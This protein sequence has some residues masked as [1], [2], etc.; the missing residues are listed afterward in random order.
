[1]SHPKPWYKSWARWAHDPD[2]LE[3]SLSETGAW[4]HLYA[5]GHECNDGGRLTG[6]NGNPL[7]RLAQLDAMHLRGIQEARAY[8]NMVAKRLK[9]GALRWDGSVLVIVNYEEEQSLSASETREAVAE[10]AR[11]Y[12]ERKRNPVTENPLRPLVVSPTVNSMDID[13]TTTT[14]ERHGEK[15][16]TQK[17]LSPNSEAEHHGNGVSASR[18]F[19][20]SFARTVTENP[21]L[22]EASKLYEDNIGRLTSAVAAELIDFSQNYTGRV[23]WVTIAFQE[24]A[25][26]NS[27]KWVYI[28]K[29]LENWEAAGKIT[30]K[31]RGRSQ[32]GEAPQWMLEGLQQG[33][34]NANTETHGPEDGDEV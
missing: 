29:I 19:R 16:V 21:L 33:E 34:S 28:R 7:D 25:K 15:L 2:M 23:E 9:H 26:Y 24:A 18:E 27:L 20:E 22:A 11:R 17:T 1:M 14:T 4:W 13:K 31:T 8:D 10:R 12:R 3:L 30:H 5:L 32:K 6:P